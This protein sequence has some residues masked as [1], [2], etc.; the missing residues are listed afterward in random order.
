MQTKDLILKKAVFADW[1]ALYRNLWSREESARYMLWSVT[2]SEVDAM[3]RMRRT[4]AYQSDHDAWTV[5][6]KKSGQAIGFCGVLPLED[7]V[8]DETGIAL[9]P[10][11]TGRGYGKQILRALAEFVF[12]QKQGICFRAACRSENA[13]SRGMILSCGFTYTHSENRTD[14]KTGEDYVLQW[15]RLSAPDTG[16]KEE[17]R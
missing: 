4:I 8:Y 17:S 1:E 13:P 10:E 3:E 6:E 12:Q 15:Y 5:Y 16:K 9:G 2:A 11:F 7:G 14:P